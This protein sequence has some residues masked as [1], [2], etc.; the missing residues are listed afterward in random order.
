LLKDISLIPLLDRQTEFKLAKSLHEARKDV[1][2]AIFD[3]SLA[4]VYLDA[5]LGFFQRGEI[6]IHDVVSHGTFH[7]TNPEGN[8]LSDDEAYR[9]CQIF[10]LQI[11]HL[12]NTIKD[13]IQAH[14]ESP[15][16]C[17]YENAEERHSP[18]RKDNVE[19]IAE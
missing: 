4:L 3:V 19:Q 9:A 7:R 11:D 8:L 6:D 5:L 14:R 2:S 1:E 10:V 13:L 16:D 12:Q 18:F 17:N 15:S